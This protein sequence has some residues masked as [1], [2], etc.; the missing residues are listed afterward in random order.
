MK[1]AFDSDFM[2]SFPIKRHQW[3]QKWDIV[4]LKIQY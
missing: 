2:L 4:M 1:N 3:R